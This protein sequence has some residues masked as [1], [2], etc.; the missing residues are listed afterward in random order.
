MCIYVTRHDSLR[1]VIDLVRPR[2]RKFCPGD[3]AEKRAVERKVR[4]CGEIKV[5][6]DR[7]PETGFRCLQKE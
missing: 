1:D 4:A 5:R 7:E 2:Q 6:I 3:D